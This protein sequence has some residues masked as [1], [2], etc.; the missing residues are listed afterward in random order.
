MLTLIIASWL[1][2][3]SS[4]QPPPSEAPAAA[5]Q[6]KKGGKGAKAAKQKATAEVFKAPELSATGLGKI[7][8]DTPFDEESV[9]AAFNGKNITTDQRDV[10]GNPTT[11]YLIGLRQR[12]AAEVWGDTSGAKVGRI[13]VL[14]P[15]ILAPGGVKVG[16]LLETHPG[17]PQLS[18]KPGVEAFAKHAMCQ[19]P[20]TPILYAYQATDWPG[21]AHTL[22]EMTALSS[23]RLTRITWNPLLK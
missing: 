8:A 5:K 16:D 7:T 22:P 10:E 9:N 13:D 2:A 4:A 12:T 11:V 1:A 18:C 23:A 14:S 6:G 3:C 17:L 21:E 19:V 20:G 15:V